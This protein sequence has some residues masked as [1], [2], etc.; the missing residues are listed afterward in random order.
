V[1]L[2]PIYQVFRNSSTAGG[3]TYESLLHGDGSGG[4][5]FASTVN[6]NQHAIEGYSKHYAIWDRGDS[7][8]Q[9]GHYRARN[10]RETGGMFSADITRKRVGGSAAMS[11]CEDHGG[12]APGVYRTEDEWDQPTLSGYSE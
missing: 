4:K 1:H 8:E 7:Y 9:S 3:A 12:F 5:E 11:L 10:A 6:E 2:D